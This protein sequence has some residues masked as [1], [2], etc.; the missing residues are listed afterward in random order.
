MHTK[1]HPSPRQQANK[2]T[3]TP[4]LFRS[5]SGTTKRASYAEEPT[6]ALLDH[7]SDAVVHPEPQELFYTPTSSDIDAS[8]NN[9]IQPTPALPV[10]STES[11]QTDAPPVTSSESVQTSP[12]ADD[13]VCNHAAPQKPEVTLRDA[14]GY[15]FS[16]AANI[17]TAQQM[18][19]DACADHVYPMNS[20]KRE[21]FISL[22]KDKLGYRARFASKDFFQVFMNIAAFVHQYVDPG[23]DQEIAATFAQAQKGPK[24]VFASWLAPRMECEFNNG[25]HTHYLCH[26]DRRPIV[27]DDCPEPGTYVETDCMRTC[28]EYNAG[29][30]RAAGHCVDQRKV[31]LDR[32]RRVTWDTILT[33]R[34]LS[35]RLL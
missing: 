16:M 27:T 33:K 8:P 13:I 9:S 15:A 22:L 28:A 26:L 19:R 1:T 10:T 17:E 14:F 4:N 20:Y 12:S 29:L 5:K 34:G 18:F 25:M 32:E 7:D 31:T 35:S 30:I 3:Q 21:E 24:W 23:L 2:S 6:S 11:T